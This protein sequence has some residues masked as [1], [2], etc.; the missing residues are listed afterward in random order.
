MKPTK[1]TDKHWAAA[2]IASGNAFTCLH[3]GM[4]AQAAK[5]ADKA[6]QHQAKVVW[7]RH[8]DT[9]ETGFDV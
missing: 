9:D 8:V 3:F 5:F 4:H 7:E 6:R 2:R 1:D